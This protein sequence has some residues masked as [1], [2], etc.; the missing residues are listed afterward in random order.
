[1]IL[2]QQWLD[3]IEGDPANLLRNQFILEERRRRQEMPSRPLYEP[4]PW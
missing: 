4:R 1:M 2:T 3:S